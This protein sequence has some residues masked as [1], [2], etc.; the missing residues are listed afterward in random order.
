MISV[1]IPVYNFDINPLVNALY[2]EINAHN[3]SCEIVLIDDC[4][5]EEFRKLNKDANTKV[6]HIQLAEN[7]GRSKIR[8]LFL[9]YV[10]NDYL[11]F[12]DCDSLIVSKDF[13]RSYVLAIEKD[14][15]VVCGGRVYPE[16]RP[17]RS[18][19]LRWK[20]GIKK[21]SKKAAERKR[22]PNKSFMTNNFLIKKSLFEKIQFDERLTEY[23]HEDTLFG[24]ELKKAGI[25][26]EHIE[27]PILNGD[28]ETNPVFLQKSEKALDNLIV[29]KN[30]YPNS[31]ELS[32]EI[33]LLHIAK[34]FK[35][36]NG[37]IR[38]Y[39]YL[40]GRVT[41]FFL[42]KGLVSL[43]CFD[44]YKLGYFLTQIKRRE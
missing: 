27:N 38:S 18:K 4:S 8:N 17:E 22:N 15:N 3:L 11:L 40:F 29:L 14:A 42:N 33:H 19:L 36:L 2:E 9:K 7:I 10:T 1:C 30:L 12:L 31:D 39:H 43:I 26:I 25:T 35:N 28:L 37:L 32:S 23:G 20:Y 5:D 6:K 24:I 34:K 41:K 21:E 44:I 13:L 16:T